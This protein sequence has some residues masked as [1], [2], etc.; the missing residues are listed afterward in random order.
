MHA[1]QGD[2]G[3]N[4]DQ[5]RYESENHE[6]RK[7]LIHH[8]RSSTFLVPLFGHSEISRSQSL[9]PEVAVNNAPLIEG[10]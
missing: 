4:G 1:V 2:R 8:A 3:H 6:P 9:L 10:Y 5:W 7:Q